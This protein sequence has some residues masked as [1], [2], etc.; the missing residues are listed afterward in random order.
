MTADNTTNRYQELG[1]DSEGG[2][3]RSAGVEGAPWP[4]SGQLRPKP[5][6]SDDS[7]P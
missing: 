6:A 2:Q 7:E 5:Q 1:D 3:D 4:A